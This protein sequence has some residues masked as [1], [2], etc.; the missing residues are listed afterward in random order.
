MSAAQPI[1]AVQRIAERFAQ[2]PQVIAVALGGSLTGGSG[3]A[4]SDFDLYI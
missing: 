2:L 4:R 1:Q 3:D